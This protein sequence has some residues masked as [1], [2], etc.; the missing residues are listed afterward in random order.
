VSVEVLAELL[1]CILKLLEGSLLK[2]GFNND[3][4]RT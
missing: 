3:H 1:R 4:P 2:S